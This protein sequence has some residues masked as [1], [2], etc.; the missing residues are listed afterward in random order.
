[1]TVIFHD[2]ATYYLVTYLRGPLISR[3][4]TGCDLQLCTDP[5]GPRHYAPCSYNLEINWPPFCSIAEASV[6]NSST[7]SLAVFCSLTKAAHL[8]IR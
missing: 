5:P 7:T 1:M 6:T 2:I 8:P 4:I 3:R